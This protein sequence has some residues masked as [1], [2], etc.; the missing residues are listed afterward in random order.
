MKI[1]L[2]LL[3]F[4]PSKAHA[5]AGRRP[6]VARSERSERSVRE[7]LLQKIDLF[8]LYPT[9]T[10]PKKIFWPY[11]TQT[12]PK[13]ISLPL[14]KGP[15]LTWLSTRQYNKKKFFT[16]KSSLTCGQIFGIF[17]EN[18]HVS[19]NS[20]AKLG[21]RHFWIYKSR[22]SDP[23]KGGKKG[24]FS[25]YLSPIRKVKSDMWANLCYFWKKWIYQHYFLCKIRRPAFLNL[26]VKTLWPL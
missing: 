11:P 22:P 20:Y 10:T 13:K 1:A 4:Y 24:F 6:A 25:V 26:W 17:E 9:Q 12:T 5:M 2:K 14:Q 16:L 21:A 8:W 19:T 3:I 7:A 15:S 18:E 23:S